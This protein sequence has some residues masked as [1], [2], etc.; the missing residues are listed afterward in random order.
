MCQQACRVPDTGV[1]KSA[2]SIGISVSKV[3][4]KMCKT[5]VKA[6]RTAEILNSMQQSLKM[7][8]GLLHS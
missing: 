6:A 4:T 7:T 8:L 1:G 5:A 2:L 3:P